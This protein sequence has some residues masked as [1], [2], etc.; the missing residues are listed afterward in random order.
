M[1]DGPAQFL[2]EYRMSSA[3]KTDLARMHNVLLH[4]LAR[5]AAAGVSIRYVHGLFVPDDKRCL[6]LLNAADP[7]TIA[8]AGD[9]A[10]LPLTRV[11][12]VID[13]ASLPQPGAR[14]HPTEG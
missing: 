13:L 14:L 1:T 8:R 10:G 12:T 11:R 7:A 4:A 3:G 6:Y 2:L 9:I 5:L